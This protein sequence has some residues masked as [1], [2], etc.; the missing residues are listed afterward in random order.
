[1]SA[2][3]EA[4][5]SE[6]VLPSL[7]RSLSRIGL[8]GIAAYVFL[9]LAAALSSSLAALIL[10]PLVQPG[11]ALT[12]G[13][14]LPALPVNVEILLLCFVCI[15]TA[16]ALLRWLAM[17]LAPR[18]SSRYAASLR[19][20]V[21][22]RLIDAPLAALS[23]ATSA[24]I[25][26]V[27]TSNIDLIN[28]GF[29][30]L[31]QLLVAGITALVSLIFALWVS[32]IL[33]LTL[34]VL[35]GL[36][37]ITSRLFGD[38]QSRI[39]R[40]YIEDTTRLFWLSE[41][42]PRRL[43][44]VR[45]FERETAEKAGYEEISSRLGAGY[46][47]QMELTATGR[48]LLELLATGGIA[49]VFLIAY[50][51]HGVDSSALIA[52]GLL[53]GRLLPFA[54]GTRQNFHQLRL[55]AHALELWRRYCELGVKHTAPASATASSIGGS[56]LHIERIRLSLPAANLEACGF[57]LRPGEMT[58]VCGES[59]AGKSSL[60]DVLAGMVTPAAFAAQLDGQRI[61]FDA[62]RRLI[63]KGAYVSQSVRLWQH[64]VRDCLLWAAPTATESE[65]REV[66]RDVGF[67]PRMAGTSE[68][69]EIALQSTPDRLSGGELQRLLLAQ[70]I[71]RQPVLAVLD[72]STGALDAASELAVVAALKRRLPK[73]ILVV[74]SH[75]AGV[76]QLAEQCLDIGAGR[77]VTLR[78]QN[79]CLLRDKVAG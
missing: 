17:R 66:L 75:R 42:F 53:L 62:Y 58:L 59:G 15:S 5:R 6:H 1:M 4:R 61:Q 24:E 60:I 21:H 35:I 51:W 43:R 49:S 28:Q 68:S 67:D 37:L 45:S 34:P 20:E 10:V 52:V 12:L 16:F 18:L 55:A 64:T 54:R 23:R 14:R 40:R 7:A 63:R 26:N 32:P 41:D 44:H 11:H 22:A 27:L 73:T 25:A 74:V 69:V 56:G 36:G 39:S 78:R 79:Q 8:A 19:C 72:E 77:I 57:D 30:S 50:R 65:L 31:L 76:A 2:V 47:R 46:R 9:S 33:T 29:N 13:G 38:E 70:V 3:P 71:L 48:L